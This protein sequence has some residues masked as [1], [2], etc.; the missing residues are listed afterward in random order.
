M[1]EGFPMDNYII[2]SLLLYVYIIK[3]FL[4]VLRIVATAKGGK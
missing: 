3:I 2:A 1:G 4:M